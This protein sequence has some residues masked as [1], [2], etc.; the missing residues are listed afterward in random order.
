MA[1]RLVLMGIVAGAGLTLP[2]AREL[3]EWTRTAQDRMCTYGGAGEDQSRVDE[4]AFAFDAETVDWP[5][6]MPIAPATTVA[7]DPRP[8]CVASDQLFGEVQDRMVHEFARGPVETEVTVLEAPI[9]GPWASIADLIA[10]LTKPA[11]SELEESLD[12]DRAFASVVESMAAAFVIDRGLDDEDT[13]PRAV[14]PFESLELGE[15]FSTGEA[16]SPNHGA[17]GIGI[18][19]PEVGRPARHGMRG[20][21]FSR[22]LR[23]T[24]EAV[25]AWADLLH[26]PA[27]VTSSR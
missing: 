1:L 9:S 5:P 27:D 21:Q 26:G 10:P 24:R 2:D 18:V 3:D 15:D 13:A 7:R 25:F 22:A 11:S 20:S 4:G 6:V 14:P 23:L 19:D 16:G 12:R 8:A 17:E